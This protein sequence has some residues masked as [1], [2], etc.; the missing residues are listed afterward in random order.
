MLNLIIM[1]WWALVKP[2]FLTPDYLQSIAGNDFGRIYGPAPESFIPI[3]AIALFGLLL[4]SLLLFD[5]RDYLKHRFRIYITIITFLNSIITG[6]ILATYFVLL[7]VFHDFA[8]YIDNTHHIVY[9]LITNVFYAGFMENLHFFSIETLHKI[10]TLH[11][12]NITLL[13]FNPLFIIALISSIIIFKLVLRSQHRKPEYLLALTFLLI[14]FFMDYFSTMRWTTLYNHYAVYSLPVYFIGIAYFIKTEFGVSNSFRNLR[15]RK[16]IIYVSI[17]VI[18]LLNACIQSYN[19]LNKKKVNIQTTD[20]PD[21]QL[22]ISRAIVK[23]FWEMIDS[24]IIVNQEISGTPRMKSNDRPEP[25]KV[26]Y[27]NQYNNDNWAAYKA[28]DKKKDWYGW[29]SQEGTTGYIGLDF[30]CINPKLFTKYSL[31]SAISYMDYM[32]KDFIL[33][34][35][36]DGYIWNTLDQQTNQTNWK[37]METRTYCFSN[38]SSYRCYKISIKSNNGAAHILIDEINFE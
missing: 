27:S 28:F 9:A 13:F 32:P 7:P 38:D 34:A 14:A 35:S 24:V 26:I 11:S 31:T 25:Y 15:L 8:S 5:L 21:R 19:L 1:P 2:R 30:G 29:H 18:L 37:S 6:A 33:E 20:T 23:P 22:S 4:I 10:F 12:Q 16:R 17:M 3:V 36:K